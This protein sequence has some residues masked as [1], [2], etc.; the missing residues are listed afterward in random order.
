MRGDEAPRLWPCVDSHLAAGCGADR[1]A[2]TVERS[3]GQRCFSAVAE[4][5]YCG[6]RYEVPIIP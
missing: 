1:V 3:A 2:N 5:S 6:L 4:F